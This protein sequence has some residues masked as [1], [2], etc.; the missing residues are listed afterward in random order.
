MENFPNNSS[1]IFALRFNS[2]T[3]DYKN[4]AGKPVSGRPINLKSCAVRLDICKNLPFKSSYVSKF[5]YLDKKDTVYYRTFNS[6]MLSS[7][8]SRFVSDARSDNRRYVCVLYGFK[9]NVNERIYKSCAEFCK[10][11]GKIKSTV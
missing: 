8:I 4:I 1:S 3:M 11:Y 7:D 5:C 9:N 10:Y 6:S 2:I